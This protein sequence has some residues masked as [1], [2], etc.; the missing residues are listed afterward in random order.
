MEYLGCRTIL[1]RD[2]LPRDES[3]LTNR[4]LFMLIVAMCALVSFS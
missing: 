1:L 2:A 4:S 3:T